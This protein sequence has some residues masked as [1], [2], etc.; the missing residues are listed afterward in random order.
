[1]G[2]ADAAKSL[3]GMELEWKFGWKPFVADIKA[4]IN[5][6][7]RVQAVRESL[8][9][10]V[11][12]YGRASEVYNDSRTP[13]SNGYVNSNIPQFGTYMFG[14]DKS[15]KYTV[16][17][18]VV[19][20]L[21]KQNMGD[22][23]MFDFLLLQEMLGL[24]PT[25]AKAWELVPMSFVI[26]WF[27]PVGNMLQSLSGLRSPAL[28]WVESLDGLLTYKYETTVTGSMT[29]SSNNK[30]RPAT[31]SLTNV[32]YIR[33]INSLTGAPPI[34]L[35]QTTIPT[36]VGKWWT[37]LELALQQVIPDRRRR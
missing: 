11:R 15:T 7:K 30:L 19:R 21:K 10:G 20:R 26:D 17:A 25:L 22:D 23:K 1:M 8:A 37:G 4:S 27:V 33:Q 24:E 13:F 18:S 14:Y 31:G 12:V 2:P 16:V 5:A 3:I 6:F 29:C 28:S 36:D 9:K 35:P 32:S 34:Y